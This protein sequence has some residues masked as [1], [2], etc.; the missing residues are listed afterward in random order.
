MPRSLPSLYKSINSTTFSWSIKEGTAANAKAKIML[1][2]QWRASSKR[3][4]H[5]LT[6][7][8]GSLW[9]QSRLF[10]SPIRV[11]HLSTRAQVNSPLEL[12]YLTEENRNTDLRFKGFCRAINVEKSLIWR[13]ELTMNPPLTNTPYPTLTWSANGGR[14]YEIK[15]TQLR[16]SSEWC[17][18]KYCT[19]AKICQ[20]SINEIPISR[21]GVPSHTLITDQVQMFAGNSWRLYK[22]SWSTRRTEITI[23]MAQVLRELMQRRWLDH[24]TKWPTKLDI[25]LKLLPHQQYV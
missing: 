25:K 21:Y 12:N 3:Q 24:P 10:L 8:T 1:Q 17:M 15:G 5:V 4:C 13:P 18:R 9:I 2:Q 22:E 19:K 7:W 14:A 23:I 20:S 11:R 6:V 16:D